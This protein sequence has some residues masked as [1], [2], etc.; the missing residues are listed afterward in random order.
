[1]IAP[2]EVAP[3]EEDSPRTSPARFKKKLQVLRLFLLRMFLKRKTQIHNL[4]I[5]LFIFIN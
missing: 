2:F 5:K 1:V 4:R 3:S